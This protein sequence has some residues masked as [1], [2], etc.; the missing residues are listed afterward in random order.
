MTSNMKTKEEE[1]I[2]YFFSMIGF[3]SHYSYF[4]KELYKTRVKRLKNVDRGEVIA[5]VL[6]SSIK[7]ELGYNVMPVGCS[8]GTIMPEDSVKEYQEEW[9]DL[10]E[11]FVNWQLEQR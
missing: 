10:Y 4:T 1:L 6:S 2:E 9:K 11:D 5:A 3:F 8:W 7:Q